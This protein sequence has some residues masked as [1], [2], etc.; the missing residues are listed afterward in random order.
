[1]LPVSLFSPYM[2]VTQVNGPNPTAKEAGI[3]T[4]EHLASLHL[5]HQ[6]P[7]SGFFGAPPGVDPTFPWKF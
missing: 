5:I 1:M 2:A 7:V 6:S 4:G 3:G